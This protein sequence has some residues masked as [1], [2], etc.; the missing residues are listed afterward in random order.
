MKK[1]LGVVLAVA[2]SLVL[3]ASMSFA[4]KAKYKEQWNDKTSRIND[5]FLAVRTDKLQLRQKSPFPRR[6]IEP[7]K[8]SGTNPRLVSGTNTHCRRRLRS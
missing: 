1:T 6:Q 7:R 5:S 3:G 4:A 8:A 2:V